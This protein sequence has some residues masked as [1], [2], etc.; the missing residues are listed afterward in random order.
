[1]TTEPNDDPGR[2]EDMNTSA[3]ALAMTDIGSHSRSS[4]A[5]AAPREN[6]A[7]HS[8]VTFDDF[9]RLHYAPVARALAI[10]LGDQ[11]LGTEA[12][13]EAMTR[14]YAKWHNV[15]SYTNPAGWTYKVG[16]NWARSWHRTVTRR[17]AILRRY[18]SADETTLPATADLDLQDALG[19]L[20][21]KYR[22]VVV[23]R[24]LMDW[25]TNET[26]E[27]L[28]LRAGTV[29]SRLSRGLEILRAELEDETAT[30]DI[31]ITSPTTSHYEGGRS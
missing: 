11:Q 31:T 19:R 14:A 16:L 30:A 26:A 7:L 13:D 8:V 20:D 28:G 15:G 5:V 4:A 17:A 27:A 6:E 3:D 10:T 9:Y 29:K 22:S 24:Y 25:D 21:D 18:S 2:L 12:A 1:M 23:C